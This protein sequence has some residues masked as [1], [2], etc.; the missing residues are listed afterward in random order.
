MAVGVR[1][2]AGL[3]GLAL[4]TGCQLVLDFSPLRGANPDAGAPDGPVGPT[5]CDVLEPND[6]LAEAQPI[7]TG[8]LQMFQASICPSGDSDFYRF[9]L[10]G[11]QDLSVLVTF[12]SGANDL[13]L[14]LYNVTN[15]IPLVLSTGEDG[16]EQIVQ[17]QDGRLP[18][19]DYAVRVFGR[20]NAVVN[21]YQLTWTRGTLQLDAGAEPRSGE[22]Q[23]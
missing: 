22:A 5:S 6:S 18:V 7:D 20:S 16:D 11:A 15:D 4:L 19:G 10:D 23:P 9:T 13:E 14:E 21:D 3:A 2:G 1:A 12:A 17:A 8:T